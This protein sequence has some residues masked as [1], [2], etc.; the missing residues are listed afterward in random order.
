M[1]TISGFASTNA[2][3]TTGWTN[4]IQATTA[5][6]GG[7]N[8]NDGVYATATIAAKNT[9][10]SSRFGGFGVS[11]PAGATI[12]SV[13]CNAEMKVSTTASIAQLGVQLQSPSGTNRG[14][15]TLDTTEPAADT[16]IVQTVPFATFGW[17]AADIANG[18]LFAVIEANQGNSATS[19]TYSLDYVQVV[20]DY[21]DAPT[22][23]RSKKIN[24]QAAVNRSYTW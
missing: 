13:T 7:A 24:Y 18:T 21:T 5:G 17:V 20:V 19:C 23:D 16:V 10:V 3:V 9:I 4:A 8:P 11:I 15:Q 22:I 1:P 6:S 14:T 2:L 12:N